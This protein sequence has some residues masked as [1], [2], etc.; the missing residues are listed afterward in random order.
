[1]MKRFL[2]I[3]FILNLICF[4]R[5]NAQNLYLGNPADGDRMEVTFSNPAMNAFIMDRL[6]MALTSHQIGVAEG[7]FAIRSGIIGYHF[8]WQMRGTSLGIQYLQ[9][10]LYS[11][12]DLRVS[13]GRKVA[14]NLALGVNLSALGRS[15]NKDEFYLVD[16]RDPLLQ[17]SMS[18]WSM[19]AGLG[20]AWQPTHQFSLGMSVFNLNMPNQSFGNESLPLPM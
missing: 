14:G 7:A 19:S 1:M 3:V 6:N 20:L 10:G 8:P 5:V 16:E 15:F 2:K 11:Y 17:G 4:G 18:H 13:Y 9:A 12:Q